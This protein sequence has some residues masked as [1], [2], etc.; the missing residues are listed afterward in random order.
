[1]AL[2]FRESLPRKDTFKE[3]IKKDLEKPKK[4][5]KNQTGNNQRQCQKKKSSVNAGRSPGPARM[6]QRPFWLQPCKRLRPSWDA[7]KV[8]VGRALSNQ[9]LPRTE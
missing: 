8:W 3:Y 1:M 6:G 2:K 5:N 4:S 9:E 7:V